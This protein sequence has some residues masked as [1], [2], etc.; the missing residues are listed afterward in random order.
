MEQIFLSPFDNYLDVDKRNATALDLKKLYE[1]FFFPKSP[2]LSFA[3][4]FL[5]WTTFIVTSTP[6]MAGKWAEDGILLQQFEY[7]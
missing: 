2:D 3:T 4:K 7:A 5:P 1:D 6:W